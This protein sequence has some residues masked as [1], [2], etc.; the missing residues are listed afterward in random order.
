MISR[1]AL[2][3]LLVLTSAS[4]QAAD[5]PHSVSSALRAA[6]IPPSSASVL[7]QEVGSATP[8]LS[9]RA[10]ASMNPAS[11]MKI[12]TTF[13]ALE[14]LGPAFRWKTEAFTDGV[15]LYLRGRGDPK[16]T[17]ESFWMLLRALRSR[18]LKDLRDV[19][20]DRSYF[21]PPSGERID[22][23]TFRPYNVPP[24]PL[25]LNFKS[26]RFVFI[27]QP[28]AKTV[29]VFAE[30]ALP[31]F[32]IDNSLGL[33]D[34]PCPE[35]RAFRDLI[36]ASFQSHP[37]RAAFTGSY[38]A[39]CGEKD[40]NVA[41]HSPEDYLDGML[42]QL[43]AELGGTWSGAL[44]DG[45]VPPTATLLYTHESE[46]LAE[47]V[48]DINKFSNNVM[49]RQLFLTLGAELLGAPAQ[50]ANSASAV[51]QWLTF[52][53]IHAPELVLENGSGLSRIERISAATMAAVLQ[54]AWKSPMM[55]EFM[56]SLPVVAADG[57]MK[58]RLHGERVAGSAHIKTGLLNDARAIAGYVLDRRGRRHVVVM[59]VN[60]PRAPE[61]DAAMDAL[62]AWTYDAPRNAPASATAPAS[63]TARPRA[64]SPA[65]P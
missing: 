22:D 14:L 47:A 31:G 32:R 27:P 4:I 41:L 39:A 40:L 35:G 64:A 45:V 51:R 37:P 15:T 26:V 36:Q 38:P 2:C 46:P 59:I 57:T 3:V 63:P 8:E 17:Y 53:G 11:T 18:G 55:P 6:G 20:L 28:G 33:T 30:P 5:L 29:R 1:A 9:Y 25:L 54:A 61:A 23:E 21:T 19:V 56:S 48:R 44:R 13:S 52:K 49:A 50:T 60:H 62:L 43:W 16:L 12:V 65:R 58:K 7:V 10:H 24:D 42:R 34:G